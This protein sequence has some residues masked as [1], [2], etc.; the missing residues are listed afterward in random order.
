MALT[1]ILC[2]TEGQLKNFATA[3]S[4]TTELTIACLPCCDPLGE[5]CR[6]RYGPYSL[7]VK[8]TLT[9]GLCETLQVSLFVFV[10]DAPN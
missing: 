8:C 5:N 3:F 6:S 4:P 7:A 1:V 9:T 10:V 2:G